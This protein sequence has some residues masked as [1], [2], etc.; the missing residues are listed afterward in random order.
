[1][2]SCTKCVANQSPSDRGVHLAGKWNHLSS[3]KTVCITLTFYARPIYVYGLCAQRAWCQ[4]E[5]S[6]SVCHV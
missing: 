3:T 1:M 2:R 6:M 5:V 4:G